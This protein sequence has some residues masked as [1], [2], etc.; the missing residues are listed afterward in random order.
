MVRVPV[1]TD[2]PNTVF[3]ILFIFSQNSEV[4]DCII[5]ETHIITYTYVVFLLSYCLM[6]IT[7]GIII[8]VTC[9]GFCRSLDSS[10]GTTAEVRTW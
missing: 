2:C 10:F 6:V 9:I 5:Y 4:H 3:V 7:R 8:F 1:G